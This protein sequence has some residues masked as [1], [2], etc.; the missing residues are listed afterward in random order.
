MSSKYF[1]HKYMC[2]KFNS[3][4]HC[5]ATYDELE[6]Y[7]YG[8]PDATAYLQFAKQKLHGLLNILLLAK[9]NG[10]FEFGAEWSAQFHVQEI[11]Y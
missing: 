5:L 9:C 6:K 3:R 11:T 10:A 7:M 1:W 4:F 8:G 2:C